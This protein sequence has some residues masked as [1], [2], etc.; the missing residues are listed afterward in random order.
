MAER[1]ATPVIRPARADEAPRLL[2]VVTAA[3]RHYVPLIGRP[4]APMVDDY[5]ARIASGQAWVLDAGEIVGVLVLEETAEGFVLDNIALLPAMQG[6]GLGA[7]MMAFAEAEA[8]RRGHSEIRLFTNVKMVENIAR[9]QR[10]GYS[11]TG[12]SMQKGFE[13]V[14]MAKR[15]ESRPRP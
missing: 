13:R 12:R 6:R 4:P 10:L 9:Y 11:E 7:L 15:L 14:F 1:Q 3:Y 8:L 5:A 2:A